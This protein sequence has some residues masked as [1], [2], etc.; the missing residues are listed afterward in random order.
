[1]KRQTS[2]VKMER[3]VRAERK[4]GPPILDN[5][6][7]TCEDEAGEHEHK[8]RKVLDHKPRAT[9]VANDCA[10]A[11]GAAGRHEREGF[12]STGDAT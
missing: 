9:K 4:D 7:L 11:C 5:A 12:S 8:R 1:V 6:G 3:G 10:C 2:N